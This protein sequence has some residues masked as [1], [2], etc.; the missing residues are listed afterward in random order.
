[1]MSMVLSIQPQ[2]L[3]NF[4][5]CT[6]L[7]LHLAAL[8]SAYDN[9]TIGVQAL[10]LARNSTTVV[11]VGQD[12]SVYAILSKPDGTPMT[13]LSVVPPWSQGI[14][15]LFFSNTTGAHWSLV[16]VASPCVFMMMI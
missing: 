10:G 2:L 4:S 13:L 15:L 11:A 5:V 7:P 1:M 6:S 16:Y 12:K 3:I 14:S 8:S 9:N